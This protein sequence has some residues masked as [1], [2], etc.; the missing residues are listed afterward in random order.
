M[1]LAY[2]PAAQAV[3]VELTLLVDEPPGRRGEVA[4]VWSVPPG[5]SDQTSD[6]LCGYGSG[7]G[8]GVQGD[9]CRRG[10]RVPV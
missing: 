7:C 3:D 10:K 5:E 2:Q 8:C 6:A 9:D 1:I 4:E